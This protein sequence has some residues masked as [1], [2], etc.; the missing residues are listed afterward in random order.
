MIFRPERDVSVRPLHSFFWFDALSQADL[1]LELFPLCLRGNGHATPE[2]HV[3]LVH[4]LNTVRV[5]LMMFSPM[6]LLHH[7]L[8]WHLLAI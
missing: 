4:L 8:C 7:W 6:Q 1:S 5:S 2:D 3:D